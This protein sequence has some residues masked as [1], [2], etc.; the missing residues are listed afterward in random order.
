[1]QKFAPYDQSDQADFESV[2]VLG[3]DMYTTQL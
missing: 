1:M 3:L 2:L